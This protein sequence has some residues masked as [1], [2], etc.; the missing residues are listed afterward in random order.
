MSLS[1]HRLFP[2]DPHAD[3]VAEAERLLALGPLVPVELPGGVAAWA[4]TD[5][6]TCRLVLGSRELSKD[7]RHWT[8]LADGRIP[9]GW[10]LI[11]LVRGAAM[12]HQDGADHRRLRTLVGKAFSRSPVAAMA[13]RVQRVADE[14]LDDLATAG[15]EEVV[16]LREAY[17]RPLPIRVICELLGAPDS[18]VAELRDPFERLVSPPQGDSA[19]QSAHTAMKEVFDQ[20]AALVEMKRAAPGRDLTSELIAARDGGDALDE[21]EL[22]ETIYLLLIAGH[23]TTVNSIVNTLHAL[24]THP[25]QLAAALA[26][27][28]PRIW[29]NVTEEGLRYSSPIRHAL[30]RY[31]VA[32]TVFAGVEVGRGEPVLASIFASGRDAQTHHHPNEF[33]HFRTTRSAH[34]AFGRGPHHCV[35][36][37]LA[38]LETAT[39]LRALFRR[40]PDVAPAGT[41]ER[42]SSI[43]LQGFTALPVRLRGK[44]TETDAP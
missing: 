5:L 24:L 12:L 2:L 30:L 25:T 40:F 7:P 28:D 3:P 13:P 34:V 18:L 44:P 43:P 31:A 15:A 38:R 9:D 27:E 10:E 16:D 20:V 8:E 14:L 35:G 39:A 37:Q 26:S 32:D 36:T 33:L 11:A 42:L 21:R 4:A 23:E 22:V 29:E 19:A 1:Q 17:A 41:P 6:P